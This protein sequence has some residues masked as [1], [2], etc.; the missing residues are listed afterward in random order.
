MKKDIADRWVA[1]LRSGEYRQTTEALR[2]CKGFCCLGVLVDI[3]LDTSPDATVKQR[4]TWTEGEFWVPHAGGYYENAVLPSIVREWAG[5]KFSDG[6]LGEGKYLTAMNDT[7]MSFSE[8][9]DVIE[10][11]WEDL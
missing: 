8:I 1:A 6:A 2:N 3:Y 5:M 10:D 11:R 4:E 7:G 9:A